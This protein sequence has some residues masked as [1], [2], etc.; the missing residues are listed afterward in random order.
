LKLFL[1]AFAALSILAPTR[2]IAADSA[3]SGPFQRLCLDPDGQ[4]AVSISL[5]RS[6]GYV[7]PPESFEAGLM[8]FAPQGAD[9]SVL[10]KAYDGGVL[11]LIVG[12]VA[13]ARAAPNGE[14]CALFVV[15]SEQDA[16]KALEALLDLGPTPAREGGGHFFLY[17]RESNGQRKTVDA[18]PGSDYQRLTREGRLRLADVESNGQASGLILYVPDP[19]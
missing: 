4:A 16:G 14:I 3:L 10:W 11:A 13:A 2:A 7:T 18:S 19:Q 17:E 6:D 8:N 1:A 9:A 5:A 15:P 12:H